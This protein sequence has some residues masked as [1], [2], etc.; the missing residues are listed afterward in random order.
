MS[1]NALIVEQEWWRQ[2]RD[3]WRVSFPSWRKAL[4]RLNTSRV[5][6]FMVKN[7]ELKR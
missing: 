7:E 4:T 5:G 1:K 3:E 2:R 6:T